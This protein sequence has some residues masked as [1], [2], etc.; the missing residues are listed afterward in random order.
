MSPIVI[1]RPQRPP[2]PAEFAELS[3]IFH[4]HIHRAPDKLHHELTRFIGQKNLPDT[5]KQAALAVRLELRQQTSQAQ[6][7]W[8]EAERE[9]AFPLFL[10]YL[11]METFI[12]T[13]QFS[14]INQLL[15]ALPIMHQTDEP[16]VLSY[17]AQTAVVCGLPSIVMRLVDALPAS[18]END[19]LM[20]WVSVLQNAHAQ[21][22]QLESRFLA[23]KDWLAQQ[24]IIIDCYG[25]ADGVIDEWLLLDLFVHT[26]EDDMEKT[27]CINTDLDHH[28]SYAFSQSPP[29]NI[30][31]S[32]RSTQEINHS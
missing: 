4:A 13:A 11:R 32:V 7:H 2:I 27:A 29:A 9:T 6:S 26:D 25:L 17:L 23:A 15:K 14:A 22:T 16:E 28:L 12:Q 10:K 30:V 20:W 8:I 1:M 3:F 21:E 5:V 31:I 18:R 24:G 19:A